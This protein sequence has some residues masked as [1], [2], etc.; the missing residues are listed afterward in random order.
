MKFSTWR[1]TQAASLIAALLPLTHA[2]SFA[3]GASPLSDALTGF[4]GNSTQLATQTAL[5]GVGLEFSSTMGLFEDPPGSGTF[6]DPT[7]QFDS[8]GANYG[9]L[10]GGDNGRN[11]IRTIDEDYANVS[12]T[13]EV[14][15]TTLDM[16]SQAGYFGLGA[17]EFGS[18]RIADWG[19][20]FSGVQLFLEVDPINPFVF[21]A[22]NKNGFNDF[23]NGTEAPPF[24]S[25][26]GTHRLR[27]SYDWFQ[28][29]ATFS[30]DAD[31]AGGAFVADVTAPAVSTLDLYGSDGWPTEPGRVYFGG[32]D[33]T[34]YKNLQITVSTPSM[35]LGDL[36]ADGNI[37]SADWVVLRNNQLADLSGKT[38]AEAYA[39]GDV[40]A[41]LANNHADFVLFKQLYDAANGVGAFAAMVA[42]VPE[43][44]AFA[45]VMLAGTCSSAVVRQARRRSMSR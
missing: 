25:G 37:T 23:D 8:S 21:T 1:T 9:A 44:S 29:K 38:F 42:S 24:A 30:I 27:L 34:N 3:W 22:K 36:T 19:T 15:W 5:G 13:A 12:F 20:P 35:R 4:T 43:P 16:F 32:D 17:A 14:T 26:A 10:A 6:F 11:Y 39:M 7:I 18:F 45:L 33:G 41:D 28:K 31:Y 40:T 2:A